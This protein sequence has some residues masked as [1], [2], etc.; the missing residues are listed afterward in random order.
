M[1]YKWV[2]DFKILIIDNRSIIIEYMRLEEI[3]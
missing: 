3:K 2:K 1:K